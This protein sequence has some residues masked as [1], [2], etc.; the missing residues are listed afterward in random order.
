MIRFHNIYKS[1][2]EKKYIEDA[3][4]RG[5]ISGDGKYTG[6][7]VDELSNIF[8]T[9]KIIMTTSCTHSLEMAMELIEWDG[10]NEVIIPSYGFPSLGTAVIKSGYKPIFAKV[11]ENNM[12]IDPD[13]VRKIVNDKTRAIIGIHYGGIAFNLDEI[14]KIKK[15]YN[16]IL[17]EDAAQGFLSKWKGKYLGTTGD[18]ACFS[19]HG[20]KN[21]TCG[22]GGCLIVNSDDENLFTRA[23]NIRQKGTNRREFLSGNAS[24]YYWVDSGS[25]YCPSDIL[26]AYLY[27]QIKD[28][29]LIQDKREKIMSMYF[30]FFKSINSDKL[31]SFSGFDGID[32]CN[33][34]L[35]Y[36]L[37]REVGESKRFEDF[38]IKKDI[39]VRRHF[40][41]LA[42]SP[43]GSKYL[44]N[45]DSFECEKTLFDRL[46]RLPI[47]PDLS[48]EMLEDIINCLY[49]FFKEKV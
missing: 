18:F 4:T 40:Y 46:I 3:I 7:V 49:I 33:G 13:H 6:L 25:S 44:T 36:L 22:E 16:L 38:M 29:K 32:G 24:K 42:H 1:K 47:Y 15:E 27:S 34:H 12:N 41:P 48:D 19:F 17:I 9:K 31:L 43:M 11:D 37:F 21:I 20:T 2:N 5:D 30:D 8:N 45:G 23:H 10:R 26:M 28:Y 35:F 39:Q 14:M